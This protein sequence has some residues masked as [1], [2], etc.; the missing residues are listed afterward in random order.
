MPFSIT[1]AGQDITL[2]SDQMSIDAVDALGQGSGSGSSQLQQGRAGTIQF[3]TSLGPVNSAV[4]A[5]SGAIYPTKFATDTFAGRT[6]AS[7]FG[8]SS[9]GTPWVDQMPG[10]TSVSGGNGTITSASGTNSPAM[11]LS[12]KVI[13]DSEV[14]VRASLGTITNTFTLLQRNQGTTWAGNAY[15]AYI[16]SA[17][18]TIARVAGFTST[19]LGTYSFATTVNFYW[20]RFR[21]QGSTLYAKFWQDGTTEPVTWQVVVSDTTYASGNIGE[22][23][24]VNAGTTL[25]M[26]SYSCTS[27]MPPLLVRQGEIVITDAG[28]NVIWGGFATKYTDIT[29][30]KVGNTKQNFTTIN[31]VDHEGQLA[32]VLINESYV[33]MTDVG[34]IRA[35]LS[36]YAPWIDLSLLPTTG[37][38]TFPVKNFRSVSVLAVLQGIAGITG[39]LVW[40]DFQKR[41][42]YISASS[43]FTAP[44]FLTDHPDFMTSYSHNVQEFIIDDNSAINRVTFYG[45]KRPS[46]D[47][48]QDVS[49][50]ANGNNKVFPTAYFPRVTSDGKFHVTVNGVEQVIGYATGSNIPANTFKSAGGLADVLINP[51][52]QNVTFDVA[53]AAGSTVLIKYQYEFPL[54]LVITDEVSHQF[55]GNPY[56]DGSIS[57]SSVFDAPTGV[58]RAKVLLAQQSFGLVSLKVDCWQGGIKSGQTVKVVNALRGINGTYLV[59]EVETEPLGAG[60]FVFHLTLGAWNWNIIDVVVKLA[61][62]AAVQDNSVAED[63]STLVVST[64]AV[65][66]AVTSAWVK[67]AETVGPYYA[68]STPV[69]D[70]HDAYPGFSTIAS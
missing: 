10:F 70:G 65:K 22:Q 4:G 56:L 25:L 8:T 32:R 68:R 66:A 6:V 23:C 62:G 59:Q 14:L 18:L 29:T 40:I 45:G 1:L 19:P 49:P 33:A 17:G 5:G 39:M 2:Y 41:A 50:L 58:Q 52:A 13:A 48:T 44:F 53:P 57:D 26:N 16:N 21:A 34:I 27:L 24:T 30:T 60:S 55:F 43:A 11:L 67:K 63:V 36:K 31:G 38:F 61:Q 47:F 12:S 3:D 46:G 51:D 7:G 20:I 54:V 42:H 15:S 28:G 69:G 9:D 35:T 64:V 37:F